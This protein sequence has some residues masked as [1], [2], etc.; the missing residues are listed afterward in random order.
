[1][2]V[3]QP[4][5]LEERPERIVEAV[6]QLGI[7][8]LVGQ[9]EGTRANPGAKRLVPKLHERLVEVGEVLA[10]RDVVDVGLEI[11][12]VGALEEEMDGLRPRRLDVPPG[13][14]SAGHGIA[15]VAEEALP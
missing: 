2:E 14:N 9:L 5:R 1:D 15:V 6:D 10:Q 8:E 7:R 13:E 12:A 11:P 4:M 3:T